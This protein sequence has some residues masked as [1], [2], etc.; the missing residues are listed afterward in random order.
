MSNTL[1]VHSPLSLDHKTGARHV[2][3]PKRYSTVVNALRRERLLTPENEWIA[4]PADEQWALLCHSAA[5]VKKVQR[6]VA[7]AE[8][9]T[10]LS[11]GDVM[12]SHGSY[13]AAMATIGGAIHAAEAILNGSCQNAFLIARPPGHHAERERGMGFCLFNTVAVAAR[14]LL[15][16]GIER[17]AIID[18]DA[19]HGN[20]TEREF[21]EESR[22]LY[23]STHQTGLFPGTGTHSHGLIYNRPIEPGSGSR[24]Q[25]LQ[26]YR[27]ELPDLLNRFQPNFILISCGFDAHKDDPISNLMLTT[28]DF[29][30]LTHIVRKS[31]DRWCEGRILSAL[32]GGYTLNSLAECAV[33][34]VQS[35][36]ATF[37]KKSVELGL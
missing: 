8:E 4:S 33:A 7:A 18:W 29:A 37:T 26:S 14:F 3:S 19:H 16:Q 11:T 27:E 35:L 32:E 1:I 21:A 9:G 2:E 24:E 23:F 5:Y 20:G 31:A 34:H 30:L 17:V 15:Q 13:A 10:M 25:L 28:E 36:N 22:V 12:I 6:E